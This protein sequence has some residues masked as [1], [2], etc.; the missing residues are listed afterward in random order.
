[1]TPISVQTAGNQTV[2]YQA[3]NPGNFFICNLVMQ[4]NMQSRSFLNRLLQEPS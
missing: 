3:N 1:M 2:T 4:H